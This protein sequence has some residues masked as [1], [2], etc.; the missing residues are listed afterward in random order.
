M[1][2]LGQG[3][4]AYGLIHADLY[5]ENVLFKAGQAYPI[6]FE[7]CGYGCWIWDIAVALCTWAWEEDWERMRDAFHAGY[8]SV[9]SLPNS[10]W[11]LLD[12]FIAT[13]YATML[14]WAC[15]FLQHDPSR[16][17]EYVPWRDDSGERM[18]K[19]FTRSRS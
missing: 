4:H 16:A 2:G 9:L 5:P 1:A 18:L 14:I 6:D 11:A 3:P 7:D 12:L 19:Y 8:Q 17:D 15:A 10:Q 13:Q